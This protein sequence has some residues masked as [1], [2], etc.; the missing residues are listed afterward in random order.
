MTSLFEFDSAH[1]ERIA[2]SLMVSGLA[3]RQAHAHA[4]LGP[5]VWMVFTMCSDPGQHVR[6]TQS[7]RVEHLAY[8]PVAA[9][10]DNYGIQRDYVAKFESAL[11]ASAVVVFFLNQSVRKVGAESSHCYAIHSCGNAI[12]HAGCALPPGSE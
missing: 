4:H 12:L 3:A 8:V 9:L 7:L 11:S 2:Q 5:G 1:N 6:A 10:I